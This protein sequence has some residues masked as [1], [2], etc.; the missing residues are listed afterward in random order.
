MFFSSGHLNAVGDCVMV[1]K[2]AKGGSFHSLFNPSKAKPK[3]IRLDLKL[4]ADLGLVG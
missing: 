3:H 1:A 4:I 2:G